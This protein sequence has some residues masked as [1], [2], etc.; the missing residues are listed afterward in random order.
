[1]GKRPFQFQLLVRRVHTNRIG[2]RL[3]GPRW[4]GFHFH[5]RTSDGASRIPSAASKAPP[6]R[7]L[8]R[9]TVRPWC[10]PC[11]RD[12]RTGTGHRPRA[13]ERRTGGGGSRKQATEHV[14]GSS[15]HQPHRP[16]V[17]SRAPGKGAAV[18]PLA[19]GLRAAQLKGDG[20]RRPAAGA[21]GTAW[22]RLRRPRSARAP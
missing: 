6:G 18:R 3:G 17:A 10:R 15:G 19:P 14:A 8:P 4:V 2:V 7:A 1:V 22:P 9:R 5:K 11:D 13:H 21:H 16:P 20:R 12:S